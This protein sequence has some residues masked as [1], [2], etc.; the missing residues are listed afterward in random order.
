MDQE[1][2]KLVSLQDV[3]RQIY[4]IESLAGDLPNTVEKKEN[5]LKDIQSQLESVNS[6]IDS[7]EKDSRKM[8]IDIEDSQTKLNKYKDQLFLVKTNKEYDA[9]NNEIDHLKEIV[10]DS[11]QKLLSIQSEIESNKE[12]KKINETEIE[13]LISSLEVDKKHLESALSNSRGELEKLN[14]NR[15]IIISDIN[16]SY[17]SKYNQL[18]ETRGS[19]VVSLNGKCCGACFSTLPPQMVIEIKS[20]DIIHSCPSC[21][22]FI[23][24]EEEPV[25]E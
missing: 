6:D 15:K 16:K 25:E 4:D 24:F 23:Y 11:E 20:N 17:L 1:L 2:K 13:D 5:S 19:G 9:L 14:Q 12:S 10:S 18:K 8:S 22:V 3:D 7:L 21:S